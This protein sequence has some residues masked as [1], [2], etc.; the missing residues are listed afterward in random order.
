MR[1]YEAE[2]EKVVS[3]NLY[4]NEAI[5]KVHGFVDVIK[6]MTLDE[7]AMAVNVYGFHF[8][9]GKVRWEV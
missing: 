8:L 3:A 5:G 4:V 2:P 6:E 9:V 7:P 1:G